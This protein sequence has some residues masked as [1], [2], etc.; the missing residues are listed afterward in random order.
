MKLLILEAQD[1]IAFLQTMAQKYGVHFVGGS[2][3][4]KTTEGIYN[5]LLMINNKGEFIKDYDK[6]H[7]FQLMDEHHYLKPGEKDGLFTF[8]D[9]LCARLYLL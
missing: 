5:T 9:K 6:L 2:V 4:K 3:A 7:L 8:D 1:T